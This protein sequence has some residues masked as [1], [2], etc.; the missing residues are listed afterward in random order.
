MNELW[1]EAMVEAFRETMKR[2]ALF[3][4][5]LMALLTFL[6]IGLAVGWLVK[7][8]LLRILKAFRFDPLCE[9]LGLTPA[10]GKAG[11]KQPIS[12]MIG[13]FSFW[14]V[15]LL[16]A[17]MGIDALDL[18]A[19]ANLMSIILGFLPHVLAAMLVALLGALLANFSSEAALIAAVNAQ[20]QEA[21]LIANLIRWGILTFTAAMVLTQLGIAK[22]IVVAAF[23][24][25]F[26]GAVLALALALGMG[27][28]TIAKD[29]LERRFRRK[30]DDDEVSHI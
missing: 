20:I 12:H 9:R 29:A 23:S 27:G 17:F 22:E 7:F 21:R 5:K 8:L 30:H 2:V 3:L 25:I 10:L 4:P 26:G 16:F 14:T 11:M 1:Q 6:L 15:F 13:R 24:I 18:P 19:T 28:R